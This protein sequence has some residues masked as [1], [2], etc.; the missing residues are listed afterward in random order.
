M[1]LKVRGENIPETI[2]TSF[3]EMTNGAMLRFRD[4]EYDRAE[5]SVWLPVRRLLRPPGRG[6][7]AILRRKPPTWV[8]ASIVIRQVEACD[9]ASSGDDEAVDEVSIIFGLGIRGSE[10]FLHSAEEWRGVPSYSLEAKVTSL[11]V[12]IVDDAENAGSKRPER[13]VT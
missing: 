12:E 4:V 1:E 6:L 10:I 13:Q 3:G 9:I 11:D 2:L 8:G 7:G 5:R